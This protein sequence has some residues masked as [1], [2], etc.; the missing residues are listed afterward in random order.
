MKFVDRKETFLVLTLFSSPFTVNVETVPDELEM[1]LIDLQNNTNLRNKFQW[2][3]IHSF[4]KNYL[5]LEKFSL[6]GAH[7]MNIMTYFGSTHVCEQLIS[8]IKIFIFLSLEY[9][10]KVFLNSCEVVK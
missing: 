5:D 1:E 6:L 10:V 9:L 7:A 2:I 3:E 8:E 4:Y